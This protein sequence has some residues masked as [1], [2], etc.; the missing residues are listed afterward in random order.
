MFPRY[1]AVPD[2]AL[3]AGPEIGDGAALFPTQEKR[4]EAG[5]RP[6]Y[7]YDHAYPAPIALTTADG[8]ARVRGRAGGRP[9]PENRDG[10]VAVF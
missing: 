10:Q 1:G 8:R 3:L 6:P 2:P 5:G 7:A 9:A 4:V